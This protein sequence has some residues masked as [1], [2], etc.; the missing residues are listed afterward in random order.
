MGG[1]GTRV[2]NILPKQYTIIKGKPLFYYTLEAY[3][4]LN[5]IDKVI[6]VSNK[7]YMKLAQENAIPVLREK[8]FDVVP[9]GN[10]RLNSIKNGLIYARKQILDNDVVLIHDASNP[11]VASNEM[12]SFIETVEEYSAAAIGTNQYHTIYKRDMEDFIICDIPRN[13]VGSG[14]SPE[15]FK[16][17]ILYDLL[18]KIDHENLLQMTSTVAIANFMGMKIKFIPANILNLKITYKQDIEIYEKLLTESRRR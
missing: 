8:Y 4:K 2:G 13:T 9:G 12:P 15:G 11:F 18:S 5:C 17:G 14:Y 3:S 6:I 10:T 7:E 1:S 16:F